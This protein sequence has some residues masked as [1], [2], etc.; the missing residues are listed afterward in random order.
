MTHEVFL[1][2]EKLNCIPGP[3]EAIFA[4]VGKK[5]TLWEEMATNMVGKVR[6]IREKRLMGYL[7][8]VAK[9]T[10]QDFH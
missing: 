1:F 7:L 9:A 8:T 4:Y 3:V 5:L 2:T 6:L 10:C